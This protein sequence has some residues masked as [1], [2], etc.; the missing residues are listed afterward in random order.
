LASVEIETTSEQSCFLSYQPKLHSLSPLTGDSF[1]NESDTRFGNLTVY[2]RSLLYDTGRFA[3]SGGLGVVTPTA[4]DINVNYA[5]VTSLLRIQNQSVRLLPFLGAL[6]TPIDRL[7]VL[8]FLQWDGAA[9]GNSVAVNSTGTGLTGAGKITDP[10]NL[11]FDVGAGYWL[12]RN[13]ASRGLTEI[14]PMVEIHQNIG[15]SAGDIFNA[16]PF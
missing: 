1:S 10:S 8:S 7:F 6:Y 12:Y 3:F 14:V 13:N 15:T 4:S 9:N 11:F 16:G 5:D 2:L